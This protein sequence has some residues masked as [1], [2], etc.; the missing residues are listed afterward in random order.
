MQYFKNWDEVINSVKKLPSVQR[1]VVAAAHDEHTLEAVRDV[2]KDGLVAPVLVGDKAKITE[3]LSKLALKVNDADIYDEPDVE[4][5]AALAV[6]LV[7]EGKGDFLMKGI[8]ETSQLL[9]AVV[10]KE[11][12]LGRGRLMSHISYMEVPAYHKMVISTDG[13]MV[14]Y[15]T[16]EQKKDVL[17][18]AVDM[19]HALG[20][21]KPKVA[22]LAAVEKVNPKMP[23]TVDGAA[24]KEMCQK[25]ELGNCVV[26]GPISLDLSLVKERS[27]VKKYESEVAG[28]ADVLLVPNICTGNVLGKTLTEM[29]GGKMAGLI[30]GAQVPIVLTSRGS[31]SEEKYLSLVLAAASSAKK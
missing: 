27:V 13:G 26:E 7:R 18:N 16:L 5:A 15:P 4:K 17:L 24:L 10:N 12:G 23:E 28:E 14:L 2:V 29:A 6:Q 9:K 11:T 25:G 1:V 3:L 30:L 19:L 20:Y 21:D 31:S 22:V 8:L